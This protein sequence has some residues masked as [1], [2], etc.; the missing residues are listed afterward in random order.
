MA[1]QMVHM[2]RPSAS[3]KQCLAMLLHAERLQLTNELGPDSCAHYQQAFLKM[4]AAV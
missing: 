3:A 4:T 1:Y 2:G